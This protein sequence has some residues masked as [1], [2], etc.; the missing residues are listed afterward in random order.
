MREIARLHEQFFLQ[1][2]L[3]IFFDRYLIISFAYFYKTS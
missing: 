1:A 3:L 2:V